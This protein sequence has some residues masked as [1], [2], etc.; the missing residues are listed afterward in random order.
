MTA[1]LALRDQGVQRA[2]DALPP[3]AAAGAVH[4]AVAINPLTCR[5]L[6]LVERA[7]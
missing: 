2:G 5:G 1:H 7:Y 4:L 3:R 6:I